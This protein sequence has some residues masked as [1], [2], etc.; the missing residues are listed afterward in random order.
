MLLDGGVQGE[1]VKDVEDVE[2]R[3]PTVLAMMEGCR[4]K[5]SRGE[6]PQKD[7]LRYPATCCKSIAKMLSANSSPMRFWASTVAAPM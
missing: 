5:K 3:V 1:G 2:I 7:K 6:H 4:R